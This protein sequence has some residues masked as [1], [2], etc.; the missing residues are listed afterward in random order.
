M[1]K[2]KKPWHGKISQKFIKILCLQAINEKIC[3]TKK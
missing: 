3:I 2:S 1:T